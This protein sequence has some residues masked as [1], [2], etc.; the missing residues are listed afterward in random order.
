M[1]GDPS[2]D[3]EAVCSDDDVTT[4]TNKNARNACTII[5]TTK[6]AEVRSRSRS[7]VGSFGITCL[8]CA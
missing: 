3:S 8:N 5:E 4:E 2:L 1:I 7:S 6:L